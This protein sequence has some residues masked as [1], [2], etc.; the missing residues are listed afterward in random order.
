MNFS[1][2]KKIL[3]KVDAELQRVS[4]FAKT[5]LDNDN[6]L[7]ILRELHYTKL[8]L[9]RA[10]SL[11]KYFKISQSSLEAGGDIETIYVFKTYDNII[12]IANKFNTSV[13]SILTLNKITSTDLKAGMKLRIKVSSNER[14][15][16]LTRNIPVFTDDVSGNEIYGRDLGNKLEIGDDGDI[17]VLSP[18]RTL[19]QS[20]L[21]NIVTEKG[22]YPTNQGFG[23]GLYGDLIHSRELAES[24]WKVKI[25]T[26]LENDFRI[27][28]VSDVDIRSDRDAVIISCT[29]ET[30]NNEILEVRG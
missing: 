8:F 13:E 18:E 24:I 19:I 27:K 16:E 4:T 26:F 7:L 29:A 14:M 25:K 2:T 10:L 6:S 15:A 5:E 23:M 12:D 20:I 30:I 11:N 17:R 1:E 9:E 22:N 3:E 21:N 28:S